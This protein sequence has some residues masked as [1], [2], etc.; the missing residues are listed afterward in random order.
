ME[1]A[2]V[3]ALHKPNQDLSQAAQCNRNPRQPVPHAVEG[4]EHRP[5]VQSDHCKVDEIGDDWARRGL[6]RAQQAAAIADDAAPRARIVTLGHGVFDL[7][8]VEFDPSFII[9][10][11]FGDG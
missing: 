4:V 3:A 9:D 1:Y 8:L 11:V 6:L 2:R 10:G 5:N 7:Q